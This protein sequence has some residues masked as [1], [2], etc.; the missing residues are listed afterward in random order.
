MADI[1]N[2][3]I[4]Y[5][6]L[7]V[8]FALVLVRNAWLGDDAFI[9]L[10]VADNWI[11]GFGLR[12]N[13][14]DRVQ[15]YTHPLWMLIVSLVYGVTREPYF[16]VIILSIVLSLGAYA[17]MLRL[18]FSSLS[19]VLATVILVLSKGFVDFTTSG[20][21]TPLTYLLLALLMSLLKER[22][23][24]ATPQ[25]SPAPCSRPCC[26]SPGWT[27]RPWSCRFPDT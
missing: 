19:A 6:A 23:S 1:T 12:W 9:T 17:V 16:S 24:K 14:A 21:E 15:V 20:L 27:W 3:R 26:C 10:R 5:L 22:S 7:G 18:A 11:H 2:R 13:V 25:I 4:V 8:F